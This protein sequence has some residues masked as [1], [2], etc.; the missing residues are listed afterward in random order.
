[1]K[2]ILLVCNAGMS[3]SM[4]VLKMEKAATARGLEAQIKALPVLN[5]ENELN[6]WDVIN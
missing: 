2:K 6:D 4:L 5:A 3:T 1:M